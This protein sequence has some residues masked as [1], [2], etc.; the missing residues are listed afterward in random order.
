[1]YPLHVRTYPPWSWRFTKKFVHYWS[2][3]DGNISS[4]LMDWYLNTL[5]AGGEWQSP[6]TREARPLLSSALNCACEIFFSHAFRLT[7]NETRVAAHGLQTFVRIKNIKGHVSTLRRP[8]HFI[9]IQF[10]FQFLLF[11]FQLC[12]NCFLQLSCRLS[13]LL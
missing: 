7:S 10:S 4:K 1:M 12:F 11:L 13:L 2:S 9:F 6:K 8:T 3:V 5:P